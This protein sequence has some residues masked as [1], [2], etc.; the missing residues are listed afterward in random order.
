MSSS[1][2]TAKNLMPDDAILSESAKE[3][4]AALHDR[5]KELE[6]EVARYRAGG[7]DRAE[8]IESVTKDL[9]GLEHVCGAYYAPAETRTLKRHRAA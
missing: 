7:P 8:V 2:P 1:E 5:I 3:H 4:I 9:R 6:D